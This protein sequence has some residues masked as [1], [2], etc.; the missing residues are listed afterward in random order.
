[1]YVCACACAIAADCQDEVVHFHSTTACQAPAAYV[2]NSVRQYCHCFS[3]LTW[4]QS[5]QKFK[6]CSFEKEP[7]VL[8]VGVCDTEVCFDVPVARET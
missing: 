7:S 5:R 4:P 6:N 1:M 3:C 8:S 2:L